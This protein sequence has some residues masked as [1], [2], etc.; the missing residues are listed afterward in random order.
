MSE[1]AIAFVYSRI[2]NEGAE[3]VK[4]RKELNTF[5][6]PKKRGLHYRSEAY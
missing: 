2:E 3:G 1:F 5:R 6:D 4:A